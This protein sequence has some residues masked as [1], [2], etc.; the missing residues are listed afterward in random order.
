VSLEN[1]RPGLENPGRSLYR[2]PRTLYIPGSRKRRTPCCT[3]SYRRW[4]RCPRTVQQERPTTRKKGRI[5]L[6]RTHALSFL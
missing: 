5:P 2:S 4:G 1:L 3:V 6:D